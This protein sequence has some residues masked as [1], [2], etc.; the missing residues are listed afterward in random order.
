VKQRAA[1]GDME[2]Q[3]TQGYRLVSETYRPTGTT[4]GEGG[5]SPKADVGFALYTAQFYRQRE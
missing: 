1:E 5:R 2:A 4:M 3:F